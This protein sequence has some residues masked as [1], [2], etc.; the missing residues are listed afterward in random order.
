VCNSLRYICLFLLFAALFV[1]CLVHPS[2]LA[3]STTASL[4]GSVSDSSGAKIANATVTV[5]NTGTGVSA[6]A[7]SDASGFY[8]FPQLAVGSYVLEVSMQ[9]FEKYVQTGVV[10]TV[11]QAGQ[12]DVVL[13]VGSVAN[14]VTVSGNVSLVDTQTP[15]S[16]Q[17]IGGQQA[18]DLP[19]NGRDSQDLVNLSAGTVNVSRNSSPIGGQGGLYPD[20]ATYA[21]SGAFRET[22]NYQMDGV[23]HNDT[24]LNASLPFPNPDAIQ[25]FALQSANFSAEYGNAAGGIVNIV[26]KSGT[27]S[28]HGSGFEF[29]RDAFM[30]AGNWFSHVPDPLHRNQ[31]GGSIGGPILKN[32]LFFFGT[33][34]G[35][36][37][38]SASSAV[39]T[40]VPTAQERSGDF[41]DQPAST[42]LNDPLTGATLTGANR[43]FSAS[44][45]DPTA[46]ALFKYVPLPNATGSQSIN[47][48]TYSGL[49][50]RYNDEQTMG[51]L[52][53]VRGNN[54]FSGHYFYTHLS[55]PAVAPTTNILAAQTTGNNLTVQTVAASHTYARSAKLLFNTTFGW[56][57]QT[58]GSLSS[59]PFS[60][61]SLGAQIANA[62]PPEI[63]ISITGGFG[64]TTNHFGIFDRDSYTFR[65]NV[66]R[67]AGRHEL[68]MGGQALRVTNTLI[69][70]YRQSGDYTFNGQL[71]GFGLADFVTGRAYSLQQGGGQFK[72]LA[73]VQWAL[74]IQDNWR[75]TDRLTLNAGLRWDP[76]LPY[77]DRDG[78]VDCWT[79]GVQSTRYPNAPA[80][81]TYGGS[82]RDA[83]CPVA[84][85]VAYW[86]QLGPRLGFAY[87]VTGDGEFSVRGGY[88]IYYTPIQTTDYNAMATT[89]PFSPLFTY[90]DVSFTNPYGSIGIPNPFPAQ[91]GPTLP[92]SN[93]AFTTPVG[94]SGTFNRNFR[95]GQT[96][97]WNL[98]VEHQVGKSAVARVAYIGSHSLYM[99]DNDDDGVV[100]ELNPAVYIP[101]ASTE[102]NTQQRRPYAN[103]STVYQQQSVAG[104]NY[105]GLQASF[106]KRMRMLTVIAN[107]TYSKSLDN[108]GWDNPYNQNFDYGPSSHNL[109]NNLKFSDVWTIPDA[110]VSQGFL[111]R[112][113]EGWQLNSIVV[114]QSGLPLTIAS[115][116]D[117]SFSSN[118]S[119]HANYLGGPIA[120][121][122]RRSHINMAKEFFNTAA[123]AP[124]TVGTFGTASKGQVQG[125]RYFDTDASLI[126]NTKLFE[127]VNLQLRLEAFDVFNNVNFQPPA[128]TQS[129]TSSFGQLTST[130]DPRVLQ[131]GAKITF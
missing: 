21:V 13:K 48:L 82:H 18:V 117:N 62:T 25:E 106:E 37:D 69:N 35:D 49:T 97:S 66:T 89:A 126:K 39:I 127:E 22:V 125:P 103:F 19:L 42:T 65:E 101:G 78:R 94:I 115:G 41:T 124:N 123:F 6:S 7:A 68:H 50:T 27:N 55:E 47:Q 107:Y 14:E 11:G 56:A 102:A 26:T 17:L 110:H 71:T 58:G 67:I 44:E 119:D 98:I 12:A 34:Q 81:V 79:P 59:A 112:L 118:G 122:G 61:A 16:N 90:N 113:T 80:G 104:A 99:S 40:Y 54:Q 24:Y 83:A 116:V 75:V 120:L 105:N 57:S 93:V 130:L 53:Y 5:T 131:L 92:G 33:Y 114:W 20:E 38:S 86:P 91:F 121:S 109:P 4:R 72:N 30:N 45:L 3:Q 10:L 64:I 15:T 74:F 129:A 36:V 85:S 63:A 73:G 8:S 111:R 77:Y 128:V 96:Q 70:T 84:G 76:W 95:P 100:R 87:Q 31:F 9:G 43:K 60:L 28:F 46:Q 23:D 108:I 52:D 51:K 2:A 32:K 1:L 29:Y 88:G